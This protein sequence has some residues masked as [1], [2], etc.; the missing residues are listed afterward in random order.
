MI[1]DAITDLEPLVGT[2]KA[3]RATGRPQA[4]HYRRHRKS[5][6]PPRPPRQRKPQPRALSTVERAEV[7][8]V[9]GS[10]EHVDKA[11]ATVYHELLDSGTYL[12][13]ISTMYRVLR[14]HNEVHERRLRPCTRPGSSPSW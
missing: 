3:C 13:S 8:A 6:A 4:N 10:E 14:E 9:R 7:R 11:P 2:R 1:D 5:P 12:A